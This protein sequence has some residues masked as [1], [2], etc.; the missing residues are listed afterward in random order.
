MTSK[1]LRMCMPANQVSS[2]ADNT[3][4]ELERWI[5]SC[6]ADAEVPLAIGGWITCWY[7]RRAL[8]P[9]IRDFLTTETSEPT[10]TRHFHKQS[11]WGD[12]MNKTK[13][14]SYVAK[15][16]ALSACIGMAIG[17]LAPIEA[18]A[19][20]AKD[21]A[22]KSPWGPA[23]EIGTLK[24]MTDSS[25]LDV[26]KQVSGGKVY[27]LGVELFGGMPI[28]CGAFGDPT[29]QIFLTHAP[30]RGDPAKELLSYSGDGVT[31]YTHTGT[32][33]DALNHFGLH[34]KIWNEVSAADDL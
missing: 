5:V 29:F 15:L 4:A 12:T 6:S 10:I 14:S 19:Q 31:M 9:R 24:M 17:G 8:I 7:V 33:I 34:G 16:F 2:C 21:V 30:S 18:G 11:L 13:G 22:A 20:I 1:S 32:H 28:C 25:R 26:L 3:S 23:D 27:D